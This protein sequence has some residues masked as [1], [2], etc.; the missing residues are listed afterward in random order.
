MQREQLDPS[1][2]LEHYKNKTAM[3]AAIFDRI[4]QSGGTSSQFFV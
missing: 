1:A 3:S 2:E 4:S